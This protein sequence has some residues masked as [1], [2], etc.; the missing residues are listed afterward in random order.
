MAAGTRT[1]PVIDGTPNWKHVSFTFIDASGDTRT[2]SG[3]FEA[4][5]PDTEIDALADALESASQASLYEVGVRFVYAGAKSKAN[6]VSGTRDSVYDNVAVRF[7]NAAT[8]AA[9]TQYIPAPA[10]EIMIAS[11]DNV[12]VT[13]TEFTDFTT[14]I[15][16]MAP[17]YLGASA[18]YTERRE[19]N[20]ATNL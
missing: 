8:G 20:Q 12:D 11:T 4:A 9:T 2:V 17:G 10:P 5:T 13:A 15:I 14:A 1:A 3:D 18:R 16:A 6:A 7:K 19:I